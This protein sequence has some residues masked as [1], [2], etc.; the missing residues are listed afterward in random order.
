MINRRQF[1]TTAATIT[2]A[3]AFQ[4]RAN[5]RAHHRAAIIGATGKGDYGHGLDL[6]FHNLPDVELLALADPDPAGRAQAQQRTGAKRTYADYREML[7]KENPT[8]V[9]IAPRWTDQHHAMAIAALN[10]GA[11]VIMEKPITTIPAESDEILSLANEKNLRIAVAHQM[12]LSPSIVMLKKAIDEGLIGDLLELRAWGKQDARA[13]GE[14]MMVLGTH[15]FDLMRLFAGDPL[16]CSARVLWKGNDIKKSDARPAGEQIGPVAGDEIHAHFAFPN[17]VIA[18]FT[19]RAA[20]RDRTGHW[21]IELIGTKSSAR[22]LADISPRIYLQ[23]ET[24]WSDAGRDASWL[25]WDKDASLPPESRTTAAAN[26]RVATDWL[27]AI[28]ENRDP[29][30][31]AKNAAKAVEMVMAVYHAA[32]DCSRVAFPL[33]DRRHPLM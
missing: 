32:L 2:A 9:S 33:T 30:C 11:H 16:W 3:A 25:R 7:G 27:T 1:L 17:A 19:S 20:L 10:A 31:S 21:G 5:A 26:H 29:E 28:N 13:G 8:L 23:S 6:I 12:R 4:T 24:K 22:I 14:D 18:S 15:L